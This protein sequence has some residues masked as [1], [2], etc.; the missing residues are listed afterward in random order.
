MPTPACLAIAVRDA[1]VEAAS[2]SR[3]TVKIRSR[4][5]SASF[6]VGFEFTCQP[7]VP[8]VLRI[9]GASVTVNP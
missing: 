3:A 4:L 8:Y 5:P 7:S 9:G 6:L 1:L 2:A